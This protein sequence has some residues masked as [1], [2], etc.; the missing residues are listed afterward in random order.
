MSFYAYGI[1]DTDEKHNV[2]TFG[3]HQYALYFWLKCIEQGIIR[4]YAS[5]IHIDFHSDFI[6]P[7]SE[8][9]KKIDSSGIEDLITQRLICYDNFIN[10]ALSLSIIKNIKFCCKPKCGEFNNVKPFKNYVSPIIL[11]NDIRRDNS[12]DDSDMIL[13]IDLDFFI[14]FKSDIIKLKERDQIENEVE[15]INELFKFAKVTTICTSHDW[16]WN[17]EQRKRVQGIFSEC[18]SF[19]INFSKNPEQIYGLG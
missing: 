3:S 10:I 17:E 6:D 11:L 4:K 15:A 8:I 9:N 2:Y 12:L 16:S 18:F 5:L 19:R 7:Q 13:D 1:I 14:D